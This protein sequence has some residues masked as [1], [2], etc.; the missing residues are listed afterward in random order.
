MGKR[1][2]DDVHFPMG[3]KG[4]R[5]SRRYAS[6]PPRATL[7]FKDRWPDKCE[8]CGER[9]KDDEVMCHAP[10]DPSNVPLRVWHE[11]CAGTD[12]S[13]DCAIASPSSEASTP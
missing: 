4:K 12:A 10:V 1:R 13:H 9:F 2:H 8:V 6:M 3:G 7:E 5:G 11:R